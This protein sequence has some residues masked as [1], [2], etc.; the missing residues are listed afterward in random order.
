MTALSIPRPETVVR[1]VDQETAQSLLSKNRSSEIFLAVVGPV[2]SGSSKICLYI[3]QAAKAAGYE[4]IQIKISDIIRT[5]ATSRKLVVPPVSPKTLDSVVAMQDLG[6]QLRETDSAALARMTL[7]RIAEERARLMG[8]SYTGGQ[9]VQPDQKKRAYVI[10]SLRHP[11][12]V[13]LLRRAYASSFALVGVVCEQ[14]VR[15]KRI[16]EKYFLKPTWGDPMTSSRVSTFINRDA[17]DGASKHGQHVTDAFHQSDFFVDNTADDGSPEQRGVIDELGR[18]IDIITHSRIV[19]PTIAETAMHHAHSARVRSAC[20]SRQVGAALVQSDG[21]VIATGTNEAPRAGGGVYGESEGD[22]PDHRCAFHPQGA[23]CRSTKQQNDIVDELIAS[24]PELAQIADQTALTA[25]IKRTRL[26]QLVEFSRA[27]HAEMDALVS[28]A[29][30]GVS[31]VGTKLFVTTF[32]CHY[33]ARHIVSA[34]VYEVQYIEPYPKSL[35]LKLHEDAIET[36]PAVWVPPGLRRD[37]PPK[38]GEEVT[39]GKVL[40]QP[41]VGIAPRLYIKAFEQTRQLKDKL[42]GDIKITPPDWG[43]EFSSYVVAYPDLEAKL[44]LQP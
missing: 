18:L 1:P 25:T 6:D 8:I 10:D 23:F 3:Q 24:V 36:N 40:F 35:A 26:G 29:R 13:Q 19:R 5:A 37:D 4:V 2:G 20:L 27:V 17:D 41:F 14:E 31:T 44:S 16:T 43:D 30:S 33:C 32:P 21:T 7:D 11:A 42:T 22:D 15:R 34:G 39:A 9:A 38:D 12:E 28:A